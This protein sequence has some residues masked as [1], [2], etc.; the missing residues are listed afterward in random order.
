MYWGTS[1]WSAMEIME[2]YSVARQFNLIPPVC[3]Q[4]EYHLFQREKVETQLPE[5]YHKIGVGSMTWSPLACGLITGKY[6]DTIP[7]KI[8]SFLQRI[9]L[10]KRES[11]WCLRSEGVSSVLLGVSNCDQLIENL[12]SIQVRFYVD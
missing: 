2:A 5:L 8:Q 10:A 9:S 1:R 3:E 12:G 6:A 7:E 11:S 4:A